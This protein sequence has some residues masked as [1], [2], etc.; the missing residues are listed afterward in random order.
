MKPLNLN[1]VFFCTSLDDVTVVKPP[2]VLCYSMEG[3]APLYD[4]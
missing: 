2:P 1:A 4:L 3:D